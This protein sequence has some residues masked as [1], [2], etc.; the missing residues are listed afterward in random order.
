MVIGLVVPKS[1]VIIV[2]LV[3]VL[4]KFY[5]VLSILA[6]FQNCTLIWNLLTGFVVPLLKIYLFFSITGS[7]Q[8]LFDLYLALL[9]K[10]SLMEMMLAFYTLD[11]L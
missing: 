5:L 6:T 10:L 11:N 2:L 3:S 1:R 9:N 4:Y 8:E 7:W